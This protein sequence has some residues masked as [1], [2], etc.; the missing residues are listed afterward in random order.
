MVAAF[1]EVH[2]DVDERG[3]VGVA[4]GVKRLVVTR[5]NVLVVLP[6]GGCDEVVVMVVR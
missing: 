2:H 3:L 5:Q 6:E 4:L 1:P